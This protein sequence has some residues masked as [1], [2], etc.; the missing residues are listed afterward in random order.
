MGWWNCCC[1][2]GTCLL[3]QDNFNRE[4]ADPPTGN[5]HV[6]SGAWEILDNKLVGDGVLATTICHSSS[7]PLG[8]FEAEFDLLDIAD[9]DEFIFSAGNPTNP[10]VIVTISFSGSPG[11][12]T[13]TIEIDSD[14]EVIG[15]DFPMVWVDNPIHRVR[16]CYAP[17]LEATV[18]LATPDF[19]YTPVHTVCIDES[20]ASNCWTALDPDCGNFHFRKG[21][22]DNWEYYVHWLERKD[23]DYCSCFCRLFDGTT[24]EIKCIPNVLYVTLTAEQEDCDALSGTYAMYQRFRTDGPQDAPASSEA[25]P[26]KFTW[27]TDPIGCPASINYGFTLELE[28][29]ISNEIVTTPEFIMRCIAYAE[30]AA[31]DTNFGFDADDP[32]TNIP[33]Q[34]AIPDKHISEAFCKSGTCEPIVLN[35]PDLRE[36]DYSVG[37]SG[38]CC[39][40]FVN[41]GGSFEPD[42]RFTVVV[43]E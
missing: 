4:D 16:F 28:C 34:A 26:Q 21:T 3:G 40:G 2:P 31:R 39:G 37:G 17:G 27:V 11:F 14:G 33:A 22:F 41:S 23:C 24:Y 43:T 15:P 18:T 1:E 35:F 9:G 29:N 32:D 19:S 42:I 6:V 38:S 30:G 20:N 12:G 13:V 5:W 7:H 25:S 10:K 8:S 36:N